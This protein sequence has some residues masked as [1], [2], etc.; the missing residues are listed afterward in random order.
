MWIKELDVLS[1]EPTKAD[2]LVLDP[3]SGPGYDHLS[4][5]S[6]S[7][8]SLEQPCTRVALPRVHHSHEGNDHHDQ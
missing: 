4:K 7:K 2:V 8:S 6:S 1:I 5:C 3:F